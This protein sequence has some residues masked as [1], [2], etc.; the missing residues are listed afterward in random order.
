MAT[1]KKV[2]EKTFKKVDK[3]LKKIGHF[4]ITVYDD[5]SASVDVD[6]PT[7]DLVTT[8]ASMIASNEGPGELLR[9]ALSVAALG[10]EEEARKKKKATAKKKA[11][12]KKKAAPKKK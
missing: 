6:C 8:L 11:A 4:N 9:M 10:L 5:D 2:T 1:V 3:K 12:V 7:D